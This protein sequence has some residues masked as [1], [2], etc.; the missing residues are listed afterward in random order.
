MRIIGFIT[1]YNPFHKGHLL[2]LNKSKELSSATHT[3]AIMS[4]S[5]VQRGEPAIIDKWSRAKMAIENGIDLVIELPV[6]YAVSSAELFALGGVKIL[7][8]L[9]CVDYLGFGCEVGIIEPLDRIANVLV[10]ESEE[11]KIVL[12]NHLSSGM[13]FAQSRSV[14]LDFVLKDVDYNYSDI[15]SKSNN[16]L[17]IE[18]LKALKS[19]NSTI[20][21]ITFSRIGSEYN[22][23]STDVEIAS[24]TAIRN[25]ILA[26]G[27]DKAEALLPKPSYEIL[28]EFLNKYKNFNTIEN[29]KDILGYLL[30]SIGE[31][32][33]SQYFDVEIGMENRLKNI[34]LIE[35]TIEELIKSASSKRITSSR[36][37]RLLV[38]M[39]LDIDKEMISSAKIMKPSFIRILG[40]NKKGFEIINKIKENS[41]VEIITKFSTSK[42]LSNQEDL[43]ILEKEILAT[44]VFY[45]G[46]NK[47]LVKSDYDYINTIYTKK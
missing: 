44:N 29:Y 26:E 7:N 13:S 33:L 11:F 1:E 17:G 45:Y 43:N 35:Y 25:L 46:I 8:S 14:A 36:I 5:F 12:K 23:L 4:G 34:E 16:I 30:L 47:A 3:I 6:V 15:V 37:R 21:P 24:A 40:S 42:S 32:R 27:L 19:L 31:D 10:N 41:D 38:H 28:V 22:D 39:L 9:N 18:Y 20:T 2:H